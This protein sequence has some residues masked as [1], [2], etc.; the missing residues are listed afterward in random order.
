MYPYDTVEHDGYRL[1]VVNEGSEAP[2][3]VLFG[4]L[5]TE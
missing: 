3:F 1:T 2:T 5:D 4:V